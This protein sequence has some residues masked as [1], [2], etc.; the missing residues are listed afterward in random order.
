MHGCA[1]VQVMR[2]YA[3]GCICMNRYTQAY[4]QSMDMCVQAR[5]RIETNVLYENA[6]T[7]KII[8]SWYTYIPLHVSI[9]S[10]ISFYIMLQK[11]IWWNKFTRKIS[12]SEDISVFVYH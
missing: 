2:I 1:H 11:P 6:R 3:N 9:Y 4:I 5:E 10:V 8:I 7:Y 12:S